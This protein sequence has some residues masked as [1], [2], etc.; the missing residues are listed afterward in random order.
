MTYKQQTVV[1]Y[2]FRKQQQLQVLSRCNPRRR[3]L[4]QRNADRL[5]A[6]Q[7]AEVRCGPVRRGDREQHVPAELTGV[8]GGR[9][10]L[11]LSSTTDILKL[12]NLNLEVSFSDATKE[13]VEI[14]LLLACWLFGGNI[15]CRLLLR[16]SLAR[17]SSAPGRF[18]W[19][20]KTKPQFGS[21]Q[22]R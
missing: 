15:L 6:Q 11:L 18:G 14:R 9:A 13:V 21:P 8:P 20:R 1:S 7:M 5:F 10:L 3:R 17:S 19:R 12:T 4:V 16:V 2:L 22:P